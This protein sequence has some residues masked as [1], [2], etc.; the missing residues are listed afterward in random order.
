MGPTASCRRAP[1]STR[2]IRMVVRRKAGSGLISVRTMMILPVV[3]RWILMI[4]NLPLALVERQSIGGYGE[5][6]SEDRVFV[7]A[8]RFGSTFCS[9]VSPHLRLSAAYCWLT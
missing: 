4:S 7:W 5:G 9:Y 3:P 1:R 2:R 6:E 8:L